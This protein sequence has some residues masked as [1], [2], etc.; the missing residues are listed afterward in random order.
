VTANTTFQMKRLPWAALI[1]FTIYGCSETRSPMETF[2]DRAAVSSTANESGRYVVVF[3]GHRVPADFGAGVAH[4]GG[5]I[6]SSLDSIGVAVVTGLTSD[7]VTHL[8][9][10]SEVR[11]IEPDP[12]TSTADDAS[13][14]ETVVIDAVSLLAAAAADATASLPAA[15]FY[16]RQWNMPAVFAPE[17]WAAGHVGSSDVV[18]AILDSGIDY[19]HPDMVGLVDL[20]RS[21][22]FVAEDVTRHYPGRLQISDL[23]NHGT[24]V[25]SIVASNGNVVA[26]LN[27]HVTLLAVKTHDSTT[28][29]SNGLFLSGIMYAADQGADVINVSHGRVLDKNVHHGTIAAFQRAVNYAFRKGALVVSVPFNDAADLDHNGDVV[30]MPCE[31]ANAVCVSATGP[32]NASSIIGPWEDVDLPAPYTAFGRSAVSVAAPGGTRFMNRLFLQM[33]LPCTTTPSASTPRPECRAR[34]AVAQ[35]VGTSFAAPHVS[36]LAALLVAQLGHGNPGLIRSRILQS[37]DDLGEPGLDSF[38]GHGR[39][40]VARALGVIP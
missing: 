2:H 40:N 33:W 32:R 34:Q 4:L 36:G 37:A 27:R 9:Q 3:T 21:R 7:A 30:R 17:A 11:A 18:V 20:E 16:P 38:Y 31:A 5:V 29:S 10:S 35:T 6:E 13:R 15:Q 14:D 23:H 1:M 24:F 12:L 8:L 28:A 26:G 25:A 39:I 19:L 22:S